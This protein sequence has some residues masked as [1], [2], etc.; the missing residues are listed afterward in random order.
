MAIW[1]PISL[2]GRFEPM[3]SEAMPGQM[4]RRLAFCES[5]QPMSFE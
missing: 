1:L 3:R 2:A 4:W 5:H